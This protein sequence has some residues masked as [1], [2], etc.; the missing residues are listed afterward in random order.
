MSTAQMQM[1]S[2]A[3]S[4][5]PEVEQE[6]A[7]TRRLLDVVPNDNLS[8][9]PHEK[10]MSLGELA[11]HVAACNR[12]ISEMALLP[13]FD[14]TAVEMPKAPDN[15]EAIIAEHTSGTERAT[16]ILAGMTNEAAMDNFEF[17][18]NGKTAMAM[19][20]IA[21]LRAIMC[22]HQYHHRGQLSVYLRELDVPLPAIYG[23]SA[24][25]NPFV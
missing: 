12:N 23:P 1:P 15:I 25:T 19:P 11:W 13:S 3:A 14:P 16:E 9:K 4:M 24:D 6:A 20:K 7:T 18:M 5:I 17:Q 10:S 2:M 8:W 22:N 21:L